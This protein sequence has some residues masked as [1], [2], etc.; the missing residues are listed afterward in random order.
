M[1]DWLQHPNNNSQ[2]TPD[3]T[4]ALQLQI[5]SIHSL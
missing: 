3:K 4:A 5:K 1:N 2:Q